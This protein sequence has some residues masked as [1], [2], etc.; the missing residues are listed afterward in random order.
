MTI[1]G[2]PARD[3]SGGPGMSFTVDPNF[4]A[5]DTVPIRVEV[6]LRRNGDA[7]AGFNL[8]YESVSGY[9]SPGAYSSGSGQA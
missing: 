4:L 3:V 5:Y 9:R 6:E 1:D 2:G 8:K 7:S